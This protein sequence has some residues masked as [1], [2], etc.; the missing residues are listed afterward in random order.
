M[1]INAIKLIEE[2]KK[3]KERDY[4]YQ[5]VKVYDRKRISDNENSIYYYIRICDDK[6]HVLMKWFPTNKLFYN[7]GQ[8]GTLYINDEEAFFIEKEQ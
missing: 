8:S 4:Y 5:D 6:N 3:A 7:N 1:I 2:Y